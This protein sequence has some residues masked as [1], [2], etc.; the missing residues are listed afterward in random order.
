VGFGCQPEIYF[1]AAGNVRFSL[2]PQC[3][4]G[5]SGMVDAKY[6]LTDDQMRQ[7][8]AR[9]YV[10]IKADFPRE[11]HEAMRTKI[12]EV[13]AKEGNPGNNIL[14][15]VPQIQESFDHPAV[16]GALTSVLG[17]NYI[18]HPHRHCHYS[19]PGR[20]TQSWHKDSYWGYAKTRNHHQWW[21]MLFYY[22]QDV[23]EEM[24]PSAIMPGTQ[25]YNSRPGDETEV[26]EHVL[27]EAGTMAL[28][29]Y[30]LWHKGTANVSTR[31][32]SML[33]FQFVRMERPQAATWNNQC[34]T[35]QALNGDAPPNRHEV[36]WQHQWRW[37]GGKWSGVPASESGE[38][39][40]ALITALRSGDKQTRL[41]A[42][43]KLGLLGPTAADAIP[44]LA[45][46][47]GDEYEPVALNAAYALAGMGAHAVNA[48]VAA[49]QDPDKERARNAAYALAALGPAATES[50]S[51]LLNHSSDAVRGYA[52]FALG[53]IGAPAS[54]AGPALAQLLNDPAEGVRRNMVEALGTLTGADAT[55]IETLART[56]TADPDEQVRFTAGLSLARLGT[57]AA[58][59]VPALQQA[60]HDQNRYVRANAVE[61]L[62]RIGTG[63]AKDALIHYLMAARWCPSTTPESTF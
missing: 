49:L 23:V 47:L 38:R 18:M 31:N 39:V 40:G 13:F 44:T 25:Y 30:D 41:F 51:E 29:H 3:K 5:S 58:D 26:E 24:G 17:P 59:A 48:L 35:W 16:R 20:K 45:T 53:E 43:D 14:P 2:Q 46:S 27:G 34:A 56:I 4:G 63:E 57:Q 32:R 7:F 1:M 36:I 8:I 9:G 15:R 61:A 62:N 60:L 37:L 50:L 12:E 28:I 21:A 54:L 11:F 19:E 52:A 6:L 10:V 42:A 33:K 22:N 55:T